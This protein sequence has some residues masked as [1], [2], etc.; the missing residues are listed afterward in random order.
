[1]LDNDAPLCVDLDG[2]LIRTDLGLESGLALLRRNPLYLFC[3]LLWLARGRAYLKRAIA[4]RA[5]VDVA[6]LP[7]DARMLA[8]LRS[9][10]GAR[11]RI[12]CTASDQILADAVAAHVGGFD[13]VLGS[14]G[15]RNLGGRV[16]AA[17]LSERH[18]EHGFDYAGNAP[19]DLHVWRHAR[20]AVVVNASAGVLRRAHGVCEVER[21]FVRE[22]GGWRPWLRAL[23]PHQWLKNTLV[24]VPLLAAHLILVP[25]AVVRSAVAFVAFCL[26]ASAAYVL[27]DLLDLDADRRHPRKRRRPFAAG[28][29]PLHGGLVA[30]PLLTL[31][32]FTVAAT[33]SAQ[34]MLVLLVYAI[35]TLAYS[36]L[37]KR[38]AMLDVLTLAALYTVRIIAGAVAIPVEAS[39]WLLAF[40]MF[41][42]LSLAMVKRYT[43]I[44]RVAASG[45][46]RVSG[47]GYR[48]DDKALIQTLGVSAGYLSVLVLAFYIDS[49]KSAALYARYHMLWLLTPILLY[50]ISRVWLLARR[51]E[52]HDDPV[53]FALT[54]RVSLGVLALFA[55]V[56]WLA[57]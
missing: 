7:Y 33:L 49:T 38:V 47:R 27:N 3:C 44:H 55:L 51:G 23:R 42:F 11:R 18:G 28:T 6:T 26:C 1:M 30:A 17:V 21:V 25:E 43:E 2:T 10:A 37:L 39:F 57:I 35:T 41:L 8:W 31:A 20:R 48:V 40:S 4:L 54:D 19:T 32:A 24:F 34:F 45:A 36:L 22:G 56:I 52:M 15:V 16:K 46:S 9:E 53:V 50:W 12:L 13:E 29:L 5:S 14:D